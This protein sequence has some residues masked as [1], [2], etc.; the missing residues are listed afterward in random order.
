[1]Q[2]LGWEELTVTSTSTPTAEPINPAVLKPSSQVN[3]HTHTIW[4]TL[5]N[6]HTHILTVALLFP[7]TG[8]SYF[9]CDHQR[10]VFLY[11][12][13]LNRTCSLT[14]YPCS[15]YSDFLEGRCLQCEA[16]KPA[17]CPVL[18]RWWNQNTRSEPRWDSDHLCCLTC[19][20]RHQQVERD[21]AASRTDQSLL[22]H[23]GH[24]ALQEWVHML[25]LTTFSTLFSTWAD[26]NTVFVWQSWATEWTW[27]PGTSTSAGGS[28]ISGCTVAETS[29][30]P[31]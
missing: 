22:Q 12:C 28:S 27:W 9:V 23:H 29:Q 20:L 7:P 18:G 21:S 10:S 24:A 31:E 3:T 13:A 4:H 17:P 5:I 8:K 26:R 14:G 25:S 11:L 30:R 16:F 15:S 19:R 6:T 1:M 2:H